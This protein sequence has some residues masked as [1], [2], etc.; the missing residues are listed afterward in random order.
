VPVVL[1]GDRLTAPLIAYVQAQLVA[2]I[3]VMGVDARDG[4]T[5]VDAEAQ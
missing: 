3:T 1:P 4:V 2:G 5:V